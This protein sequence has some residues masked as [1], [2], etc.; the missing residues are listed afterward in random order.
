MNGNSGCGRGPR[1]ARAAAIMTAMTSV[2]LLAAACGSG[3]SSSTAAET[4]QY[5]KALA[6]AQCMREHGVTSFP[7]PDSQGHFPPVQVGRSVT[8]QTVQSAEGACRHLQPGGGSSVQ[9]QQGALTQ[10]LNFA[11]CMRRHGVPNFPDP[12]TSNG[13]IGYNLAGINT[14][15]PQYQSAQQACQ[16]L[17]SRGGQS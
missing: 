16:S 8:Q 3:S 1:R 9:Q 14:H 13:G 4:S 5:T 2:A 7:D 10:A 12:V 17:N 6:Y 11:K 15:S